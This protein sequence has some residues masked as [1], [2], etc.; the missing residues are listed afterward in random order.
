[1]RKGHITEITDSLLSRKVNRLAKLVFSLIRQMFRF[2]VDRDVLEFDPTATIRKAKIGG[3]PVER[4]RVLSEDEI[5]L[6]AQQL[7]HSGVKESTEIAVLIALATCCRIGELMAAKW[8][9]VDFDRGVW[10]IPSENSK[11]GREHL[12]YLSTVASQAFRRLKNIAE[13]NLVKR[14][15]REPEAQLSAWVYPNRSGKGQV[16]PKTVT[17]QL[18]DRQRP[19]EDPMSCRAK[20]VFCDKLVLPR[21]KWTPHDLRRTGATIMV[22]LGVLPEVAERC[23]NH[24]EQNRIKRIYQRHGYES[25]MREAWRLLGDRLELLM[26]ND[27]GSRAT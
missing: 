13:Q 24:V 17:K 11:N 22:S 7:P 27:E 8:D 16:C 2:A 10:V 1:M 12:V 4:D 20:A 5:A 6:L 15:K 3:P 19:G 21:G 18:S 25:E 26:K 23:L 9:H 14:Q